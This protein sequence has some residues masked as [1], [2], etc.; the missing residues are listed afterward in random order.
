[1]RHQYR[2]PIPYEQYSYPQQQQQQYQSQMP[3]A[4]SQR[5]TNICQLCHSQ[6]HYNYQCQFAGDFMA[7]TQKAFN[8]GRSYSHQDPNH[9]DW[10]HG[11]N[12]NNDPNGQPFQ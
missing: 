8:Q 11:N 4:P 2:Y 9:R 3:P 6:G 7:L 1:M 5:A 10:S 12:D